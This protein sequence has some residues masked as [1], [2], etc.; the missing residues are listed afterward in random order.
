MDSW[1]PVAVP[2]QLTVREEEGVGEEG[3][4]EVPATSAAGADLLAGSGHSPQQQRI[5]QQLKVVGG[6]T[7][8]LLP[9][10]NQVGGLASGW[11][12][13]GWEG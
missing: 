8:A 13:G 10:I 5:R 7:P 6:V 4:Q 11:L 12:V 1:Q 3:E 2:L 9:P